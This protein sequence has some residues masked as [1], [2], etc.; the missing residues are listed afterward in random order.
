MTNKYFATVARG[1]EDIAAQE[2]K[3]LG[4]INVSTDF[5]G[6]HFEGNKSL[7]YR[8]NLWARTIFRVLK[9]IQ[10]IKS[11]NAQQL[12]KN[13]KNI[14]WEEY[15]TINQTFAVRCTGGNRHLNHTHFTALQIKNAII[16][17][18]REKTGNRSSVSI[19]HPDIYINAHIQGNRC[20][21]SL[22]SSGESLHRRGFREA[23]GLAPL[24]ETLA[25]ALIDMTEWTAD[26]AFFDP[27]CGSGILP[28][29]A[30]LKG[31]K[32]APGLYRE[33]FGFQTWLDFDASLWHDLVTEAKNS[34]LTELK[35]PIIGSDYSEEVIN[36][37][38]S[39]S[40]NCGLNSYVKFKQK[41]LS[42]IEA[43]AEKG[44]IICNPPYGKRI[45]D[46]EELSPLYK[47]LGDIFKQRFKGWTGYILT[48]NKELAK[49]VG[50]RASRRIRVYNGSLPCTLLKY[51][52][53]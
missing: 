4:A 23:M 49:K 13:V 19:T 48:G 30:A 47:Q 34:Q 12:Y 21:I 43:P 52:L 50:L 8:V 36:Q 39:N 32:I 45:S 37:A 25:A 9:P 44:V 1:L 6:V 40:F 14:D 33:R 31:L 51:E 5:T 11:Y 41:D 20:I 38:Y 15:L 18:Q 17:R 28:L 46:T 26:I 22:D 7:L 24:K 16:D 27:M 42:E 10:E 29:E 3:N 35:A 2:L 53:Y